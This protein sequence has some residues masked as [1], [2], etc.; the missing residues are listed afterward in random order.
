MLWRDMDSLNNIPLCML[1]YLIKNSST[2]KA[3]TYGIVKKEICHLS[4]LLN[5]LLL[6][7][8]DFIFLLWFQ[9]K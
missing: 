7:G 6:V 8:F 1:F 3:T 2:L 9:L 5:K 4:N